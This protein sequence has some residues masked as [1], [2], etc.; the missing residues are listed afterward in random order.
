MGKSEQEFFGNI[1][2][3]NVTLTLDEDEEVECSI[4][5][6]FPVEEKEY[7]ALTPVEEEEEE[8]EERSLFFFR[9]K[10]IENADPE[11]SNIEREEEYK[12]VMDSF[13]ELFKV[14]DVD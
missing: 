6:I 11:L 10:E 13:E 7:I 12:A 8:S 4:V 2:E 9:F 5:A 1:E 3:Y 14:D